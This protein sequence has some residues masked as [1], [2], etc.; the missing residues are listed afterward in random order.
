[1]DSYLETRHHELRKTRMT[2]VDGNLTGNVRS[3]QAGVSARAY[4]GGYW[5]FASA[6]ADGAG[7]MARVRQQAADNAR[8]MASFGARAALALPG[9]HHRGEQRVQGGAPLSAADCADRM[10]ALHARCMAHYPGLRSTRVIVTDE[11]HTKQLATEGG[12]QSV[13]LIQ[14]AAVYVVLVGED[15]H[16]A[17]IEL[18]EIVSGLGSLADIDWS[19]ATLAP[20]LDT[21]HGHLQAKRHAVPARGGEHTVVL[22]ADLAGMLA[23]E[24]MGHP[25]EADAVL[26]G[27]VTADLQGQR[28]ASE[29]ITMVDLAHHFQGQELMCPVYVDDEG[30]PAEDVTMID[31]GMLRQFMH[32][33]ETAAR[34]GLPPSGNARAYGPDDEPLVRMRNTGILPGTQ[35]AGRADRRRRRRLPAARHQ[36][37]PGRRHHRVHVRRQPRLRDP[38]GKLGRRGARHHA[39]GLGAEGAAKRG[40]RG[41]RDEVV[42][43]TATA[44]RSSRWWCRWA[45]R[46]CARARTWGANDDGGDAHLRPRPRPVPSRCWTRCARAVSSTRRSAS[47]K[48]RAASSTWPTTNPACCAATI[49]ASCRSQRHRRRPPGVGRRQRPVADGVAALVD[50]CGTPPL[51]AAGRGQRGVGGPD[52][53]AVQ[54]PARGRPGGTGRRRCARCWTGAPRT[55]RR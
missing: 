41:P 47:A 16:G 32:S 19:L 14:R 42:A 3:L 4:L 9:G 25:C 6:P 30:T 48:R 8:A 23:H 15:E 7:V 38:G 22:S 20:R 46:R 10:A 43:A 13:A 1:M 12:A 17:P 40:R 18:M 31:R 33:R 11:H 5:G 54:G 21:L 24:A 37:R 36:Q 55:R 52:A 50:S 51:G 26:S 2:L 29:L 49:H 53:C 34:L 44:A 35:H 27:A 45:G 39:V 28:V